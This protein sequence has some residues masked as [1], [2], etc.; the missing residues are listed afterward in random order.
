MGKNKGRIPKPAKPKV[1]PTHQVPEPKI[2]QV[3]NNESPLLRFQFADTRRLL[4]S[5]W[6]AEEKDRL[7]SFFKQLEQT[8]WPQVLQT[9]G[10][11]GSKAGLGYT[12]IPQAQLPAPL[13]DNLSPDLTIFELRVSG[14]LRVFAFR[15]G[16]ICNIVWY[17]REHVM[18]D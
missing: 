18:G 7:F 12:P 17:D 15:T 13:P 4:V 3:K 16:D 1:K 5:T 2:P 10:K 8:K 14:K 6:T 9:G 11:R